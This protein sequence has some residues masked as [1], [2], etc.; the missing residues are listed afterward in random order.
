MRE[1]CCPAQI[2]L[3]PCMHSPLREMTDANGPAT[4]NFSTTDKTMK[5]RSQ[6]RTRPD[7]EPANRALKPRGRRP[8][9]KSHDAIHQPSLFS[10]FQ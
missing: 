9:N 1:F 7:P 4:E 6:K 10:D 3:S 8:N 2:W 5:T